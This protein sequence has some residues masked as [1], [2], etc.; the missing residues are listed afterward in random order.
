MSMAR[1]FG[2]E[3][4][5]QTWRRLQAGR[6]LRSGRKMGHPFCDH[7]PATIGLKSEKTPYANAGIG[8]AAVGRD[9]TDRAHRQTAG[10]QSAGA[11]FR[12]QVWGRCNRH[13]RRL[14]DCD[15][16]HHC[17]AFIDLAA[18][19]AVPSGWRQWGRDCPE[20]ACPGFASAQGRE[21]SAD[22][23]VKVAGPSAWRGD[24]RRGCCESR[25][26][27]RPISRRSEGSLSPK[28]CQRGRT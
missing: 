25:C 19:G 23:R 13:R 8:P 2:A 26:R 7:K 24:F 9:K 16:L 5:R 20:Q 14:A 18:R 27:A 12:C 28:L 22:G 6:S 1:R 3:S 11:C 10:F 15:F 17:A 21:T 4:T